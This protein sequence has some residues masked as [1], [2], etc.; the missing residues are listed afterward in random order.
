MKQK[1]IALLLTGMV[2]GSALCG[3]AVAAGMIAEPTWQPIYVDGQQVSMTAYNI[4][5]NN[6]VKLRDIGQQVGFNVYWSDGVQ[7]QSDSAY[8][9]KAPEAELPPGTLEDVTALRQEIADRTNALRREHGLAALRTDTM[10]SKAAQVRAEEL[11][12]TTTY[13]HSRPDGSARTSVCDCPYT[14]E[15]IHR[16]SDQI[17]AYKS[18]GLAEYAV[19][20]WANSKGHLKNM[21]NSN[22]SGIGVGLARGV[23][24]SGEDCWYCVQLFL[25][26]GYSITWVDEPITECE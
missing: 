2:L 9:G 16:V 26:D 15:N 1:N 4:A 3:S 7:V 24:A 25:Y 17:L 21:L 12:A 13:E 20:S 11:A 10:L 23:N 6:Y 22:V 5:G 19:D 14:A 18:Q 8:T